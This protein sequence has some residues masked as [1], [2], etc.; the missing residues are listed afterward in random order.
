[1]S[2]ILDALKKA[3][4]E[5][6]LGSVPNV[7]TPAPD[8]AALTDE[9]SGRKWLPWILASTSLSVSLI[10]LVWLHPWQQSAPA[11]PASPAT[12]TTSLPN[13]AAMTKVTA[14]VIAETPAP[15]VQV[16][17]QVPPPVP[18]P[19]QGPTEARV[20]SKP[21]AAAAQ[22]AT[23]PPVQRAQTAADI[24]TPVKEPVVADS[25]PADESVGT[26]QNLPRT[27]QAEIPAI[28]VNGYIYAK[29]PLDRSVLINQKLLHEGD[30]I[31]PELI[32]EKMLPK[33]AIL[34]YKGFRYRV[35]F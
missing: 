28:V 27:I 17:V 6:K 5:R 29:N 26:L 30:Q 16:Q 20:S 33:G 2:Y 34:N 35:A 12:A 15:F 1:M 7:Y 11:A 22:A 32:L 31:A 18:Q 3:E 8:V 21:K 9:K 19:K 4:S 24:A 13:S 23:T 10:G 14:P 25:P